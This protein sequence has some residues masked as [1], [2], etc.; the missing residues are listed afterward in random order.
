VLTKE[1]RRLVK[2]RGDYKVIRYI[3]TKR[4]G[5]KIFNKYRLKIGKGLVIYKCGALKE[6]GH[7]LECKLAEY[8]V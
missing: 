2:L 7:F 5:I 4:I 6:K 3:F 1:N 8:N